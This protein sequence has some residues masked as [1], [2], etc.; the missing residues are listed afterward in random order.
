MAVDCQSTGESWLGLGRVSSGLGSGLDRAGSATWHAMWCHV[1][2]D[3]AWRGF[4]P[5]AFRTQD[6]YDRVL[7]LHKKPTALAM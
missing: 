7:S 2:T 6:L 4:Y 1:S 3:V 5:P